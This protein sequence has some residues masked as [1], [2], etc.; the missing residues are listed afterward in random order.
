M[1]EADVLCN[2]IGILN[3]ILLIGIMSQGVLKCLG[4]P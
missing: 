2:R 4:T 1:E 3:K